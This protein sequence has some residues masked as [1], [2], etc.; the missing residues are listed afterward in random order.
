[1]GDLSAHFSRKEFDCPCA[2]CETIISHDLV[3]GLEALR[4]VAG[5]IPLR[6]TSGFRCPSHNAKVGGAAN[7]KHILGIAADVTIAGLSILQMAAYAESVPA[8]DKG[9]IGLYP[10][11]YFI[12]VDVR[13]DGPRRWVRI[14]G[15]YYYF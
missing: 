6:I 1:M 11:N 8:F 5:D 14:E 15:T 2:Q 7:S 12:H 4:R 10:H 13:S 9:G 3:D